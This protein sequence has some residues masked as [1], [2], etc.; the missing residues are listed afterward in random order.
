LLNKYEKAK[1]LYAC[2]LFWRISDTREKVFL[3]EV[4][5]VHQS[6]SYRFADYKN[7]HLSSLNYTD[8]ISKSTTKINLLFCL[9]SRKALRD[10]GPR[11]KAMTDILMLGHVFIG[12]PPVSR[13]RNLSVKN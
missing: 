3:L 5:G 1:I 7:V 2:W 8:Y 11:L 10:V 6:E 9:K 13:E 4:S 12:N